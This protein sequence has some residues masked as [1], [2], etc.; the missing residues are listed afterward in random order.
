[1][2]IKP[3]EEDELPWKALLQLD[4][5]NY[6]FYIASC[7]YTGFD[8]VGSMALYISPNYSSIILHAMS[9]ED[10]AEYLASTRPCAGDGDVKGA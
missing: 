8:A 9:D 10:Y 2:F 7:C 5:G 6:A 1:M 4:N 3:G